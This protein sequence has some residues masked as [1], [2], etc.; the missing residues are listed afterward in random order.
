MEITCLT[1]EEK[2]AIY[3]CDVP[4]RWRDDIVKAM[5]LSIEA[6]V[7]TD[8]GDLEKCTYI[9]QLNSFTRNGT[10][11]SITYTNEHNQTSTSTFN[12]TTLIN[13]TMDGLDPKCIATQEDWDAMSIE[14]KIQ[15]IIDYE[16]V[17]CPG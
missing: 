7:A 4:K 17:C 14:E 3:L 12:F 16:C 15:A 9:A 6:D 8:C 1:C 11:I 5:C 10:E 13:A 2:L